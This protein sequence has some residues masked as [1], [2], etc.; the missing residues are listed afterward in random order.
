MENCQEADNR[1]SIRIIGRNCRGQYGNSRGMSSS[2]QSYLSQWEAVNLRKRQ[3]H[4][5]WR[6]TCSPPRKDA[7]GMGSAR[8]LPILEDNIRGST[9]NSPRLDTPEPSVST[10]CGPVPMMSDPRGYPHANHRESRDHQPAAGST[11][12]GR[13][14][15]ELESPPISS[16]KEESLRP[17]GA[18]PEFT[19]T[20]PVNPEVGQTSAG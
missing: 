12:P 1:R 14:T 18:S 7:Q 2:N 8:V 19:C 10:G 15:T 9:K 4:N 6:R 20:I 16:T 5:R 11:R 17:L 3:S 13:K